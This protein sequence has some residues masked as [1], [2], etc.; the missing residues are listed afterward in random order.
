MEW[1]NAGIFKENLASNLEGHALSWPFPEAD[2][3]E[4][5]PPKHSIIPFFIYLNIPMKF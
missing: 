1:W 2:V 3:T 5:V 4:H